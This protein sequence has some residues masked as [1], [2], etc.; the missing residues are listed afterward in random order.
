MTDNTQNDHKRT[1]KVKT[2]A[3]MCELCKAEFKKDEKW[4]DEE[5]A[6]GHQWRTTEAARF[7]RCVRE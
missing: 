3:E 2:I 5:A 4:R 6:G 7:D 1:G